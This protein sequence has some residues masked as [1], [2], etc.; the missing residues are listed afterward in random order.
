LWMNNPNQV[1]Q[2]VTLALAITAIAAIIGSVAN[3][4]WQ[5]TK[6]TGLY[7]LASL[8]LWAVNGIYNVV[9]MSA[10]SAFNVTDSW[11]TGAAIGLGIGIVVAVLV[12]TIGRTVLK[13]KK[14]ANQP[15]QTSQPRPVVNTPAGP[16]PVTDMSQQ[17]E[18]SL[19]LPGFPG[20][21]TQVDVGGMMQ[22]L[23]QQTASSNR[24]SKADL[25]AQLLE[26][27]RANVIT[28]DQLKQMLAEHV[29]ISV[30]EQPQEEPEQQ[31][32]QDQPMVPV[33]GHTEPLLK[34]HGG[35]L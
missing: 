18:V 31:D 7:F 26:L 30:P 12:F 24:S 23:A 4:A 32:E 9:P 17:L 3:A 21:A 20:G 19:G 22:N 33:W 10:I 34:I 28:A 16:A 6:E 13:P 5:Q 29:D 14:V 25:M 1:F 35:G 2:P 15:R 11:L 27:F 8:L